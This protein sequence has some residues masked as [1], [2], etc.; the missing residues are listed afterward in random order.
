LEGRR[1]ESKGES[2][3]KKKAG[4]SENGN[5]RRY[6]RKL[7]E[8]QSVKDVISRGSSGTREILLET[9]STDRERY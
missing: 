2:E 3:R 1:R 7:R 5:L 9:I 6:A 8:S 4:W